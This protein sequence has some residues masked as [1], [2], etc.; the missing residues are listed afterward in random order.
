MSDTVYIITVLGIALLVVFGT[1]F[2]LDKRRREALPKLRPVLGKVSRL[3]L[4]FSRG[5]LIV[6]GIALA[7]SFIFNEIAYARFAWYS[8]FAYIALGIIF[9]FARRK[10]I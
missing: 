4:W 8:I 6:T 7:S 3:L 5:I 1:A 2:L 9:Q 10:G